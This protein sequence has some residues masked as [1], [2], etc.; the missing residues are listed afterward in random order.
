MT[1]ISAS[2]LRDCILANEKH[3][4]ST[5]K[6]W[7][8][9]LLKWFRSENHY[10]YESKFD[11]E[12]YVEYLRGLR[13]TSHKLEILNFCYLLELVN[14]HVTKYAIRTWTYVAPRRIENPEI[15][16][17]DDIKRAILNSDLESGL[18][19]LLKYSSGRR[20]ADL[21]RLES[22]NCSVENNECHIYLNFCKTKPNISAYYFSFTNDLGIEM[23]PY[24][25]LFARLLRTTSHPF[26]G[27]DFNKLRRNVN[28][29]LKGLRSARAIHYALSGMS[30][31]EI[32]EK[33]GWACLSTMCIYIRLPV[34]SIVKLGTYDLVAEKLNSLT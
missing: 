24:Y 3:F 20:H 1:K 22:R 27:F 10:F 32:C 2:S 23:T 13:R 8:R 12:H 6:G 31:D 34:S 15:P 4:N 9:R 33:I 16:S 25:I 29:S 5:E 30:A 21:T 14:Y 11:P 7:S 19:L 28:F 17:R 26:S 18:I